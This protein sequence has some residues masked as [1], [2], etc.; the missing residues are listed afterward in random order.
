MN[1]SIRQRSPGSWEIRY[2]L[3]PDGSGKHRQ[4]SETVKGTRRDAQQ[5]LRKRMAELD[6]G[7][8]VS[9]E[10]QK[11]SDYLEKWLEGHAVNVRPRTLEGYRSKIRNYILPV[12]GQVRLDRLTP[13]QVQEVYT[14]MYGRGLSQASALQTHRL[15]RC[16]R[17]F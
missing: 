14:R 7:T 11:V 2:Y 13:L 17:I 16:P 5:T 12:I 10:K 8:Y 1:G 6:A 9:P 4:K 15:A 3:P